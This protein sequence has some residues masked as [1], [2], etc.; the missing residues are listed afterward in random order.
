MYYEGTI[1]KWQDKPDSKTQAFFD[2]NLPLSHKDIDWKNIDDPSVLE[3][4]KEDLDWVMDNTKFPW[5][6]VPEINVPVKDIYEEAHH[7]LYTAC[8]TMHRPGSSGWL[9][10]ALHGISSVH[11]NCAEDYNLPDNY[12]FTNSDWTDISKFCPK[13]K[14]WMMD[15]MRY[16]KFMRVRFMALLPGGWLGAHRDRNSE[17]GVGATNVA[18]SNP[19]NCNFVFGG[20]GRCDW[21]PGHVKKMNTGLEHAV[22]NQGDEPRIHMIFDGVQSDEFKAQVNRGYAKMLDI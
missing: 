5:I 7:L 15:E 8:Y 3:K 6:T 1:Q 16:T 11:T 14:E 12:E 17:V 13:T 21:E 20:Y 22:W 18:I 2:K 10:L 4:G 9:S 19:D